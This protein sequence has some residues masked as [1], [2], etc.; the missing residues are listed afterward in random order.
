MQTE[1]GYGVMVALQ[2]L[3][4]SAQVRV[5]ISQLKTE[6]LGIPF[7]DSEQSIDKI[8]YK[9]A[10]ELSCQQQKNGP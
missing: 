4:L 8:P 6:C 3:V 5:L 7:F 2:I 1:L 10:G 9:E